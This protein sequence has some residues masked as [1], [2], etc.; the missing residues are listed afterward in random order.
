MLHLIGTLSRRKDMTEKEV[1][2]RGKKVNRVLPQRIGEFKHGW[3]VK[4]NRAGSSNIEKT[5]QSM[6]L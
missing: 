6:C 1:E 2:R 3:L 4:S 5:E